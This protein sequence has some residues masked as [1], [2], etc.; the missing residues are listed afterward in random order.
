M[1][2]TIYILSLLWEKD[3]R[4]RANRTKTQRLY[5]TDYQCEGWTEAWE[6]A[7]RIASIPGIHYRQERKQTFHQKELHWKISY[8][9]KIK[10]IFHALV[11]ACSILFSKVE[12]FCQELKVNK[13]KMEIRLIMATVRDSNLRWVYSTNGGYWCEVAMRWR[14]RRRRRG[15]EKDRK[16]KYPETVAGNSKP[17]TL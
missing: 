6:G 16:G 10:E 14:G 13:L 7:Y 4:T 5:T 3:K 12:H 1:C 11:A 2:S 8:N 15:Q 9:K 17:I